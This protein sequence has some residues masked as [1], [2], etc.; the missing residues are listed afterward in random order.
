M[1]YNKSLWGAL[2][3]VCICAC[4]CES[5]CSSVLCIEYGCMYILFVHRYVAYYIAIYDRNGWRRNCFRNIFTKKCFVVVAKWL[6]SFGMQRHNKII[7]LKIFIVTL[8]AFN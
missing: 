2:V 3:Y 6:I 4:V 1:R 8:D 7:L 5:V